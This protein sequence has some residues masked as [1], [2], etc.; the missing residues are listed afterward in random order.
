MVATGST[1]ATSSST[2]TTSQPGMAVAGVQ[3]GVRQ[4]SSPVPL[5]QTSPKGFC[6]L[7]TSPVCADTAPEAVAAA[8]ASA[9]A[10]LEGLFMFLLVELMLLSDRSEP[11]PH[12]KNNGTSIATLLNG[13]KNCAG[14]LVC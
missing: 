2:G 9:S 8:M 13:S 7:F 5:R 10:I 3:K 4:H 6:Q 11:P 12:I 1:T 14:F